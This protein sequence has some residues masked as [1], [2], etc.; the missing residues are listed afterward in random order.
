MTSANLSGS[1]K[2]CI[3]CHEEYSGDLVVCPKDGTTLTELQRDNLVGTLF[4][5]KY[6]MLDIIGGGG[7]GVVYRAKHCLMNR[8]VAIKVLHRHA[9][10][11]GDALKRFQVES[12]AASALSMPNIL[13]VYDF[14]LSSAGQPYMV[15]DY[16]DGKSL[17]DIINSEGSVP[18]S[19]AIDIFIQI[20][21]AM[22]HAHAKG[23]IHRDIKPSN[24]VLVNWEGQPDFVKIVDFGIAK[25]L[26]QSDSNS[27]NLTRT[28]EVFGS[29]MYMS[30]EQW[31]GQKLDCRTDIYSLGAVMYR[32]LVGRPLFDCPD[33]VQLMYKQVTELPESFASMG[34]LLPAQIEQIVFRSLAKDPSQRFQSMKELM[35]ALSQF[36]ES[37]VAGTDQVNPRLQSNKSTVNPSELTRTIVAAESERFSETTSPLPSDMVQPGNS[38]KVVFESTAAPQLKRNIGF[39]ALIGL[40]IAALI[41]VVLFLQPHPS[42]VPHGLST[43]N[44]LTSEENR[45]PMKVNASTASK[46]PD[47]KPNLPAQSV[48][49]E[50]KRNIAIRKSSPPPHKH[51]AVR[52]SSHHSGGL[53]NAIKRFLQKL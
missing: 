52:S 8:I 28:G 19:R 45:E 9:A 11:N 27:G 4:V 43:T 21:N 31:K 12:Q 41:A 22:E 6:E 37:M 17:D 14:G 5:D 46:E 34:V 18:L 49:Q 42:S 38:D 25:L 29:P 47:S 1:E 32:C 44:S 53:K 7:M 39:G 36:K 24:V 23:I 2:L 40:S 3:C 51:I 35:E 26:N 16:L 10:T 30:P 48:H 50:P 13:T 15:M 33:V 20:C